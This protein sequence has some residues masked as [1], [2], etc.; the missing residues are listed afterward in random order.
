MV[1][2]G[3]QSCESYQS[4][5]AWAPGAARAPT[6]KATITKKVLENIFNVWRS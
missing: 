6:V 4:G 1:S 5:E 2:Q 3:G